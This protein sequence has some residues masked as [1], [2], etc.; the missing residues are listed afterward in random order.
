MAYAPSE[1]SDQPGQMPR[2]IWVSAGRICHFVKFAQADLSLR[3][4]HMPFC[5]CPGWSVFTGRICH[6]V[7]FVTMRLKLHCWTI[8]LNWDWLLDT[9]EW[10]ILCLVDYEIIVELNFRRSVILDFFLKQGSSLSEAEILFNP[11]Q[12]IIHTMQGDTCPTKWYMSY[13]HSANLRVR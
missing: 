6:F 5:K 7:G 11:E 12:F 1:D 8:F 4:V 2:L 9:V 13:D 3:W 10:V